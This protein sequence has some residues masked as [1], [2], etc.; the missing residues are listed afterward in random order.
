MRHTA[1][2]AVL[3]LLVACGTPIEPLTDEKVGEPTPEMV[4]LDD[5]SV[6]LNGTRYP[7]VKFKSLYFKVKLSNVD[8]QQLPPGSGSTNQVCAFPNNMSGQ[9]CVSALA[10]AVGVTVAYFYN[11][12]KLN[13]GACAAGAPAAASA[14]VEWENTEDAN[15]N[16]GCNPEQVYRHSF[17]DDYLDKHKG[18]DLWGN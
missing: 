12:I 17:T 13:W 16:C 3:A 8:A 11:C 5:G 15:G 18:T 7:P 1:A 14:W 2:L 6:I 4:A 10:K 9:A